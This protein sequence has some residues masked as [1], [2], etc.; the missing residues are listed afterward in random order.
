MLDAIAPLVGRIAE[1]DRSLSDQLRRAAQSVT[2]NLAESTGHRA[3]NRRLR[4]ESALGSTYETRAALRV[5]RT[6]GYLPA[7][8]TDPAL[9]LADRVA[10]MT[11]RLLHPRP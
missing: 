8:Q 6:W 9:T 10:A 3:G 5:A 4:L 1:H 11:Y 2:L 7:E